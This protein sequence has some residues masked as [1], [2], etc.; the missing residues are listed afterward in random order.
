MTLQV[1]ALSLLNGLTLAAL[2]FMLA[3]GF[4]LVF[5]LMRIMN[6]A[7]GGFYL[8]GG[9]IGLT[10]L[11]ATRNFALAA[12]AAGLALAVVGLFTERVLLRR[13]R[14]DNLAE[15]LLTIGLAYMLGDIALA[16][17]GGDPRN[18]P[19]PGVIGASIEV[20]GVTYPLFRLLVLAVGMTIGAVIWLLQERTRIGA[21]VRAGVDDRETL[22]AMGVNVKA[23]FTWMFAFGAFLA[24]L[25]GV[26]GGAFLTLYPGADFEILLYAL[27]VVIIGGPGSLIGAAVGSLVVGLIDSFGKVLVPELI[28]FTIFLPMALILTWRP[29]GLFGRAA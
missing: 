3:S 18:I 7:H 2:L 20:G 11:L 9:Y 19:R 22:E 28:Y 10:V 13:L 5:G 6:L 24:G 27:V 29:Y 25:T 23:L 12:L 15:V 14:G 4:T 21:T 1:G 16:I 8:A 17:W 26:L